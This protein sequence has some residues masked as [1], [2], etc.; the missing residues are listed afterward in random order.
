MD[1]GGGNSGTVFKLNKNGDAL[2]KKAYGGLDEFVPNAITYNPYRNTYL[3]TGY[4]QRRL[5]RL[6]QRAYIMEIDSVG[7]KLNEKDIL[8]NYDIETADKKALKFD[9]VEALND[10]TL[11]GL[12][13]AD[14]LF[15]AQLNEK[16][17]V[18]WY[19]KP[20]PTNYSSSHIYW[21]PTFFN[22]QTKEFT[23]SVP[24]KKSTSPDSSRM[25]WICTVDY[26]GNYTSNTPIANAY[27][28]YP[29]GRLQPTNDGGYLMYGYQIYKLDKNF[30]LTDT[31]TLPHIED[32]I[33]PSITVLRN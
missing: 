4:I 8:L 26:N 14:T 10:T 13:S 11:I 33:P 5:D 15:F 21:G 17:E 24:E 20:S 1:Q 29:L 19:K 12:L 2:W 22:H 31:F 30:H 25:V 27:F 28:P 16:L 9:H 6:R 23:L 32:I 18:Q 7:N 3:I